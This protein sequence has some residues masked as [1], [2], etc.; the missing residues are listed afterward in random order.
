MSVNTAEN[1]LKLIETNS[2]NDRCRTERKFY[3][4]SS[5]IF[6][7]NVKFLIA[8]VFVRIRIVFKS[9]FFIGLGLFLDEK[10][11]NIDR[12]LIL[13]SLPNGVSVSLENFLLLVF[14]HDRLP[15]EIL[16]KQTSNQHLRFSLNIYLTFS[17]HRIEKKQQQQSEQSAFVY[18][19]KIFSRGIASAYWTKRSSFTWTYL[20]N[21]NR[22]HLITLKSNHI[23]NVTNWGWSWISFRHIGQERLFSIHSPIHDEWYSCEQAK[24]LTPWPLR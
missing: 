6:Q 21:K 13:V 24:I 20:Q 11:L 9:K 10:I 4:L 18:L 23:S 19:K 5:S 22:A 12:S 7:R 1:S 16:E 3:F 2:I 8:T 15:S 14:E 17:H